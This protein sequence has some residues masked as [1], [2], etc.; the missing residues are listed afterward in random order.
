MYSNMLW[1]QNQLASGLEFKPLYIDWG[2]ANIQTCDSNKCPNFTFKLK[3]WIKVCLLTR[4][5]AKG[6]WSHSSDTVTGGNSFDSFSI[7]HCLHIAMMLQNDT[8][9][10]G[11]VK[12][13]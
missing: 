2:I 9:N 8:K 1:K 3:A 11:N 6:G 10:K 7:P 5:H 12:V 4:R 13:V